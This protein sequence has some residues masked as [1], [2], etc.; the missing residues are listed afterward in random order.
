MFMCVRVYFCSCVGCT[1]AIDASIEAALTYWQLHV[2]VGDHLN[3]SLFK[4]L[5][6]SAM[7]EYESKL[8]AS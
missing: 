7:M 4:G 8:S 3:F 5:G 2:A 6:H 1:G